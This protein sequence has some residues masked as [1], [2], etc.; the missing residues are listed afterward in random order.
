MPLIDYQTRFTELKYGRDRFGE[1][2]GDNSS[3]Q[4]YIKS[5]IPEEYL[6]KTGGDDFLLRGGT[7]VPRVVGDDISRM[8]KLMFGKKITPMI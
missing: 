4:P 6:G 1:K 8:T 3:K 2:A 5:Q 7:L